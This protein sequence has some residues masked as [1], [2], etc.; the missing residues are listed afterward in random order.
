ML[1]NR[2]QS[3]PNSPNGQTRSPQRPSVSTESP[4]NATGPSN[5]YHLEHGMEREK[6]HLDGRPS[7]NVV[8]KAHSA[9]QPS[10]K[11]LWASGQLKWSGIIG[12]F[13]RSRM[14]HWS[15]RTIRDPLWIPSPGYTTTLHH[16]LCYDQP[17]AVATREERLDIDVIH[18]KLVLAKGEWSTH[19][20]TNT[21]Q[22]DSGSLSGQASSYDSGTAR[23]NMVPTRN[24]SS[25]L[26]RAKAHNPVWPYLYQ[27]RLNDTDKQQP[28]NG[29]LHPKAFQAMMSVYEQTLLE[30]VTN[31]CTKSR[32]LWV[33]GAR[34]DVY[35]RT[36]S[37][38]ILGA[39]E[40]IHKDPDLNLQSLS[41]F[42]C[43]D[44][45]EQ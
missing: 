16:G 32:I 1:W 20:H 28:L 34:Q 29:S 42:M 2:F 5:Y 17:G 35:A 23:S 15:E 22:N 7:H 6:H 26:I 38:M 9:N 24:G 25:R 10:Y 36:V 30:T 14:S 31:E 8:D 12:F 39:L 21:S 11:G 40:L 33:S 4:Y 43:S 44:P 27:F 19:C 41:E 3:D 45:K 13:G 37:E 18:A